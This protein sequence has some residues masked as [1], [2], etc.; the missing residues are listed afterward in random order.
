MIC[1]AF[2][3]LISRQVLEVKIVFLHLKRSRLFLDVR[4]ISPSL[5]PF[6]EWVVNSLPCTTDGY[7]CASGL[8]PFAS[9]SIPFYR[10]TYVCG[11][12]PVLSVAEFRYYLSAAV[13]RMARPP[14]TSCYASHSFWMTC[15][16]VGGLEDFQLV[17]FSGHSGGNRGKPE[18]FALLVFPYSL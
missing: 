17:L 7:H 14:C 5:L 4:H 18:P 12:G 10:P 9:I 3:S 16:V 15:I 2:S 6:M 13:W 1:V 8:L 11:V